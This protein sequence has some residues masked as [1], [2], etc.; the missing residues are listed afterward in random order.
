MVLGYL[1]TKL[2]TFHT[3]K[4]KIFK[5][6]GI[7]SFTSLKLLNDRHLYKKNII[8]EMNSLFQVSIDMRNHLVSCNSSVPTISGFCFRHGHNGL[9]ISQRS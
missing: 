9:E 8:R 7:F 3:V 6:K 2:D 1:H 4:I 5:F